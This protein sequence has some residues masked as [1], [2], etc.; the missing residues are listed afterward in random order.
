MPLL[1]PL[2]DPIRY[3]EPMAV[4]DKAGR[5]ADD[6]RAIYGQMMSGHF[7]GVHRRPVRNRYTI[8]GQNI[9]RKMIDRLVYFGVID[10]EQ[11]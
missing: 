9:S 5:M 7:L 4:P 11:L 8:N 3:I 10:E 2:D 1:P 6:V